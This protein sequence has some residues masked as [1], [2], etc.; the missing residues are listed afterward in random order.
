MGVI[1]A[2]T[3]CGSPDNMTEEVRQALREAD[4]IIGASRLVEG[5]PAEF[6]AERK[7]A[8]YADQ[9]CE[10]IRTAI[11]S[12]QT[13]GEGAASSVTGNAPAG[14]D[15]AGKEPVICVVYS[16]DSGFYS[17]T[18]SLLPLLKEA[19]IAAKVL[20]GISSIQVFSARLQVPWQ[21]WLLVSAHG[22]DC[23]AVAAVMQG[24]PAFFL[25]G[26]KLTPSELCQ[27][28]TEAGLGELEV[29]VGERLTYEDERILSGRAEEFAKAG[30]A[31]LSVMLAQPAE[32]AGDLTPGIPDE[33]FIRGEVPMTKE[34][35]RAAIL[36]QLQIRS[37]DTVWDV[38]AGTGSVSIEMAMKASE[39][40]V[41]AVEREPEGCRLIRRNREKF[42]TFNL[43]LVEGEAPSALE[44][45]PAPDRVFIGGSDGCLAEIIRIALERNPS[46]RICVSAIVL[47]TMQE[48]LRVMTE[49][50]MDTKTVQVAVTTARRVGKSDHPKH[51]MMAGNPI[52]IITGEKPQTGGPDA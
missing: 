52:F 32:T 30:F 10:M 24:R 49:A 27:Q 18:R 20:P 28:L 38:G 14:T 44:E 34:T 25:T 48:A 23:D 8:I 50:G 43:C 31:P 19:G 36:G 45:L 41:Y 2:G 35:V 21:D 33:D 13:G 3:G 17:G 51:M 16:G 9:I 42:G 26:G 4:L 12:P 5:L 7:A 29:A 6:T 22:T 47:E 39:G 40:R 46:V 37:T 11:Q 1:L 15:P